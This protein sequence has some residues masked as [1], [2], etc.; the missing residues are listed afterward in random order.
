MKKIFPAAYLIFFFSYAGL[1]AQTEKIDV[2]FYMETYYQTNPSY[3]G[4]D[5]SVPFYYS[6]PKYNQ[7]S[8]NTALLGAKTSAD[9][10]R[11]AL[12]FI[13][14][15]FAETNWSAEP[16]IFRNLYEG[17][18]GFKVTKNIWIDTGVFGSHIGNESVTSAY[19]MSP[20]QSMIAENS[21][22]YET[23][24]KVSYE[25]EVFL[26]SA[27]LLNGWQNIRENNSNKAFGWQ[28]QYRLSG[29]LTLNS[30]SYYGEGYNAPDSLKKLRFFHNFY[31]LYSPAS[32][33]QTALAFDIGL[34][35]SG[36]D[37]KYLSWKGFSLAFKYLLSSKI[38]IG[39][40]AEV[41]YD[42]SGLIIPDGLK[43]SGFSAGFDYYANPHV[44]FR[45]EGKYLNADKE[46][47]FSGSGRSKDRF[48]F[49]TSLSFKL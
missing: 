3:S 21:P 25:G 4:P 13:A 9:D 1:K 35:E 22:Y 43:T 46:I 14:G 24:I 20:T 42:K 45:A 19:N 44:L 28:T 30:S 17:Y 18:I 8:L 10:Y 16:E 2:Y 5:E 38:N 33:F 7:F 37:N 31:A 12:G 36:K 27:L 34:Q 6:F 26:I 29:Q 32:K 41:Y 49:L 48:S 15:D 23:G 39:C 11:A 40:R 47:F